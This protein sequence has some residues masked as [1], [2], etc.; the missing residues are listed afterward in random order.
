MDCS[1][2]TEWI[3]R[4]L[5]GS[6]QVSAERELD[7]HLSEC[8]RCRADLLL[9]SRIQEALAQE[10]PSGLSAGFSERVSLK[11]QR[12]A[13][14]EKRAE[15][16]ANLI[17]VIA[18]SGLAVVLILL[19]GSLLQMF[20]P[21]VGSLGG[22]LG[23]PVNA[24]GGA[25]LDLVARIAHLPAEHMSALEQVSRPLITTL[26]ATLIGIIPAFWGLS[27]VVAFLSE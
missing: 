23:A 4:K 17:P 19:R 10:M 14:A 24:V 1:D 2:Y 16:W 27:R 15:R 5:E 26:S 18:F 22:A 8:S 3:A 11:A 20:S 13:A 21:T 12:L 25:F 7:A 6:L 9:Q